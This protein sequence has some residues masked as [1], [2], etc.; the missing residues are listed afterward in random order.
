MFIERVKAVCEE[1]NTS[2]T[3]V[4]GRIGISKSNVTNWK[5]GG[6]PSVDIL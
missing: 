5:N 6:L 2:V 1:K 4:A 3:A